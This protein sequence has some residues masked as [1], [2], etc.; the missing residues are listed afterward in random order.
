M[1]PAPQVADA[2][3][4]V[5]AR[6][7]LI[8][9]ATPQPDRD[10]GSLRAFNLMQVLREMG[11]RVD[12]LPD[13]RTSRGSAVQA[14]RAAG[15]VVHT[16]AGAYPGWFS[17]HLHDYD[18]LVVSR[19]HLAEFIIPLARRIA[20]RL[21]IVFDTVDL[22]HLR[23]LREAELRQDAV[24]Q[25]LASTTRRRELAAVASADLTW[26]VSPVE[27][28]LLR[29]ALP[30]ARVALLPNLHE[31]DP[32]PTPMDGRSGLLFIGGARH[33]PNVD[34]VR[35]LVRDLFPRVCARLPDCAL[36]VVGE[37]LPQALQDLGPLPGG[38]HLHGHVPDLGRL[39][40]GCRV[41]VAPLRFG[42]GVKGKVNL[43]MAAGLPV[44]ATSCAAEGMYLVSDQHLLVA[45]AAA[46]FAEA[47]VRLHTDEGL[48]TRLSRA[49]RENIRMHF[50]FD[51]ARAA[52]A[53][54][55]P[56]A[57]A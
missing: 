14:L 40:A 3:P 35:W 29:K 41:G 38:I 17:R 18:A 23:E 46:E 13:D 53:E 31:L 51:V 15:V 21:R 9:V 7:L 57:T 25:R 10:S 19:Y 48:W 26:V 8:D 12:F 33:A 32:A 27:K 4:D 6:I 49:G 1:G 5:G 16:D 20:P 11:Y 37:G 34:A 30:D 54:S 47:V 50:S 42:A 24:L 44:V 2:G 55:L 39:L 43:Y 52:I 45:D 22:H 36:H 28:A 56:S